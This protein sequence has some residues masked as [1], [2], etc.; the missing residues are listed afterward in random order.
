MKKTFALTFVIVLTLVVSGCDSPRKLKATTSTTTSNGLTG[1]TGTDL[2]NTGSVTDTTTGTSTTTVP[3]DASHC[4]FSTDGVTGFESSSSHIGAYTLCQSSTDKTVFYVQI[5]TPPVSSTGDVNVCFIPHTTSGSNSI[6][7]G[8][9]MCGSFT[10]PKQVKKITFVKYT[11][12][13]NALIN[14]VMFFKDTSYYYPMYGKS[15]MTL[16][17]YKDCM[18][19]L[20]YGVTTYCTSFKTV[21]QYILKTF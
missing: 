19:R 9:P 13:A 6:Y 11:Q 17:A 8:N 15:V 2:T 4:K 5:K 14:S 20:N 16:D 21:G 18:Y 10:N 7:I 3:S 1:G 12:Y